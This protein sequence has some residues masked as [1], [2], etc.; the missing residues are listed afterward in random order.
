MPSAPQQETGLRVLLV[1]D[2]EPVRDIAASML[3]DM[4]YDVIAACSAEEAMVLLEKETIGL[5]M[6]D[7]VMPGRSGISLARWVRKRQ[8]HLPVLLASGYSE[9]II[10]GVAAEFE[11]LRKPFN[12]ASLAAAIAAACANT[13]T[14]T[15]PAPRG[16]GGSV[17]GQPVSEGAG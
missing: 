13:G 10:D 4:G 12:G 9:E 6:T 2:D 11:F 3:E 17:T 15:A 16:D 7:M 1:E 5:L 8:P 14:A